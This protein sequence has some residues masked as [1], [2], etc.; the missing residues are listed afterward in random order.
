M[1]S[2]TA[3]A[4]GVKPGDRVQI[5]VNSRPA[6]GYRVSAVVD[7]PGA[8]VYFVDATA[9]EMAGV[10]GRAD[11]VDLVGLRTASGAEGRVAAEVRA[12]VQG[13]G[14]LVVTGDERGTPP[15]PGPEPRGRCWCCSPVRCPGSCC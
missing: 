1:D 15:R 8:G 14:L 2:A 9:V 11:R 12:K 4:A 13:A 5:V 6:S 10:A 7:A 3:A